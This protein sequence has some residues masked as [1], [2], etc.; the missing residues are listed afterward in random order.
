MVMKRF[1]LIQIVDHVTTCDCCGRS[2]LAKTIEM[3]DMDNDEVVHYG[4][5]CAGLALGLSTKDGAKVVK[6]AIDRLELAKVDAR[7]V[8][9]NTSAHKAEHNRLHGA[10]LAAH[11]DY[12]TN[13]ETR[14]AWLDS[15]ARLDLLAKH[16][17]FVQAA[18]D[19]VTVEMVA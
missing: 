15:P 3:I 1:R 18:V 9:E 8:A 13:R 14:K 11:A 16:A 5:T 7:R 2:K 17:A 12:W 4:T 6:S 19:A 10:Y